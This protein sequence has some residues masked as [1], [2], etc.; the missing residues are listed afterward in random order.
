MQPNTH[1]AS[2]L[3]VGSFDGLQHAVS[4]PQASTEVDAVCPL[5]EVDQRVAVALLL[6][7]RGVAV[8]LV[9]CRRVV[10]MPL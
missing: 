2:G 8:L 7:D 4:L 9:C 1:C 6:V 10:V 5:G 3:H